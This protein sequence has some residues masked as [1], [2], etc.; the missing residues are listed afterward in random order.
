MELARTRRVR[1]HSSR[2]AELIANVESGVFPLDNTM[3]QRAVSREEY[4]TCQ[5]DYRTY[6]RA[7]VRSTRD[8]KSR[9]I[10]DMYRQRPISAA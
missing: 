3:R 9:I 8:I 7:G 5:R 1:S 6:G 2:K 4:E 10:E